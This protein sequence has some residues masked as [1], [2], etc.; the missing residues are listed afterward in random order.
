MKKIVQKG[1]VGKVIRDACSYCSSQ[2][3]SYIKA[4][5]MVQFQIVVLM[6]IAKHAIMVCF[7]SSECLSGALTSDL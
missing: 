6:Q 3:F 5:Y 2:S 1:I 4:L 7:E